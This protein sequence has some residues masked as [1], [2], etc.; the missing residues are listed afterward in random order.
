MPLFEVEQDRTGA[1]AHRV[2][3]SHLDGLLGEQIFPVSPGTGPDE[4]YLLAL[5]ASGAPVVVELVSRLDDAVLARA[6]DHAGAAGR[7]TRG[8]FA[9]RY[10]GGPQAFQR[11][12]A[13]F[14]DSVPISRSHAR[15]QG[16]RLI[17]ICQDADESVLNAVDFLR[18][19]AAPVEV[20]RLGVVT[21]T[22]GRTLVDVS[23]L[24]I[25]PSSAPDSPRIVLAPSPGR[26]AVAAGDA[27]ATAGLEEAEIDKAEIEEA[28]VAGLDSVPLPG[29]PTGTSEVPQYVPAAASS[30][31]RDGSAGAGSFAE[32]DRF[33]ESDGF[34]EADRLA[35][36]A[37]PQAP[38]SE[39]APLVVPSLSEFVP[40]ADPVPSLDL[41]DPT[42]HLE[43]LARIRRETL[44]GFAINPADD[45]LAWRLDEEWSPADGEE[46]ALVPALAIPD[47]AFPDPEA[48]WRDEP[49]ASAWDPMVTDPM[50]TDDSA[51][52]GW[53]T[54]DDLAALA[55]DIGVPTALVWERPRRGQRFDAV[56]HPDGRIEL[57][58]GFHYRHPDVAASAVSGSHTADGW[59]VWRLGVPS[60]P[61][62]A[63]E[64]RARFA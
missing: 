51:P 56:L 40:P 3:D 60:G 20:L 2:V 8:Q 24:V 32:G 25:H 42:P 59:S 37:R 63:E 26:R 55:A 48:W 34:A 29:V 21:T 27:T 22:D 62:L 41:T 49:E 45:P 44:A 33:A 7:M 53:D 43:D 1:T 15:P 18:R 36:A 9:A 14:Y 19:P 52:E 6:L 50:V 17:I 13:G 28:A 16:P 35:G 11:D 31:E 54:D 5:D 4:P 38:A 58:D 47:P 57:S 61:S 46:P 10:R 12:V 64:F 23:P 39:P 30:A